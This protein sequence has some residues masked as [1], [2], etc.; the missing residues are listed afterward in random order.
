MPTFDPATSV[1]EFLFDIEQMS[2]VASIGGIIMMSS[3]GN[4]MTIELSYSGTPSLFVYFN[5]NADPNAITY[6]NIPPIGTIWHIKVDF[7]GVN[8]NQINIYTYYST[9]GINWS[10]LTTSASQPIG[11]YPP[12]LPTEFTVG[13]YFSG[14][15]GTATTG[16]HVGNIIVQN[17]SPASPNCQISN[18]YV[19]SSGQSAMLFYETI[20]GG[21]PVY[22][23]AL[24]FPLTFFQNE[25]LLNPAEI[26]YWV[27]SGA[28]CAGVLFPP[29]VQV[30][31]TDT[32]T[33]LAPASAIA[34]GQET[35]PL[36]FRPR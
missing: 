7:L 24:N 23:S 1:L 12:E 31:A 4:V 16:V 11:I 19:T 3:T 36:L 27:G 14:V 9:D 35:H 32:V 8:S 15:A 13:P 18:A 29:G 20:I 21:V 6:T 33:M 10:Q 28:L 2:N 26:N 17:I 5:G 22:P 25:T 30:Y 34:L